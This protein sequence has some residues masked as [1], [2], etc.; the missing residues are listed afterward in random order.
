[1]KAGFGIAAV[2]AALCFGTA[3]NA[4]I[5]TSLSDSF[6]G[7]SV[8]LTKWNEI[9]KGLQ[10]TG[11]AGYNAPSESAGGLSL[12]GTA[13]NGYWYGSSL[14]SVNAFSITQPTMVSVDRASLTGSGTAYRSSLWIIGGDGNDYIHFSQDVAETGWQI[15]AQGLSSESGGAGDAGSPTYNGEGEGITAFNSVA[16][17]QGSHTMELLF[18]PISGSEVSIQPFLDNIAGPVYT[19]DDWTATDFNVILTGQARTTDDTVDAIFQNF[20]AAVVPEPSSLVLA[21]IGALALCFALRCSA[22]HGTGILGRLG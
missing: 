14:E 18:T 2:L 10:E 19:F 1:M 11:P 4:A 8:D 12:G 13:N 3:A 5:I 7:T 17:D 21:G 6:T 15:N 20:N 22:S 16:P 9:D